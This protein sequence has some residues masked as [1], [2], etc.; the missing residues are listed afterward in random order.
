MDFLVCTKN[1]APKSEGSKLMNI[2]K[3]EYKMM[4]TFKNTITKE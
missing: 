1:E 4:E 3:V 2:Q